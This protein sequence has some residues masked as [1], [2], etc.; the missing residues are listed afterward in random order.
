MSLAILSVFRESPK[1][2]IQHVEV[3]YNSLCKYSTIPFTLY[4][5]SDYQKPF[6]KGVFRISL[7]HPDWNPKLNKLELFRQ[8]VLNLASHFFYF[9]L[10]T[11]L[12]GNIDELLSSDNPL[13]MLDDFYYNNT[14]GS[15]LMAW[16]RDLGPHI[17]KMAEATPTEELHKNF[18]VGK[19]RGDQ[20]F[21][22][23]HSPIRPQTFQNL[24]PGQVVSYKKHCRGEGKPPEGARV[25][26]FHGK[27]SP[28][29]VGDRWVRENWI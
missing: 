28:Q 17:Y 27:P 19:G 6:P 20:L 5:I 7:K 18:P 26:C 14:F 25:V 29:E 21:I 11:V 3:L 22:K 24:W 2:S 9:D 8:D 10:D 23:R 12:I 1:F 4:V 16:T 15:G 13:V